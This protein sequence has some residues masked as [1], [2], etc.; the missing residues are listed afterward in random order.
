MR[1]LDTARRPMPWLRSRGL[2]SLLVVALPAILLWPYR[3][4]GLVS[5]DIFFVGLYA[6]GS[7]AS[8]ILGPWPHSMGATVAWRPLVL[9]S[10]VFSASWL[11]VANSAESHR[12]FN[13]LLHGLNAWAL[14]GLT[15]RLV[16]STAAGLLAACLFVVHPISHESVMWISG[17]TFPLVAFFGL[18]LLWWTTGHRHRQP[19]LQHSVGLIVFL[20][21]LAS[22]EFAVILPALV[23]LTA[24]V[25]TPSGHRSVR[26]TSAF[27]APYG[28]LLVL[29]LAFRWLWLSELDSD[30]VVV[31][32]ASE[33]AV[34]GRVWF[35][36]ARNSLFAAVRLC[37]WPWFPRGSEITMDVTGAL[38]T[39]VVVIAFVSVVSKAATRR[40][41]VY[42]SAFSVVWFLPVAAYIGFSDRLGYMSAAG[43]AALIAVF[44]TSRLLRGWPD[45]CG[46]LL[47]VSMGLAWTLAQ[48][49]HA[50]DWVR[51][52]A[53]AERIVA[54]AVAREPGPTTPTELHF[55]NVPQRERSALVFLTYFPQ[56]LWSRYDDGARRNVTIAMHWEAIDVVLGRLKSQAIVT[57]T[58]VYEWNRSRETFELQYD[59]LALPSRQN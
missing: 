9:A 12:L 16:G 15:T 57:P 34:A 40:I 27:I 35:R 46:W 6:P 42:W 43:V 39:A 14:C 19:W 50:S 30:V 10:Y 53:L 13:F 48:R 51:A 5:D 47:V 45:A 20:L 58:R 25:A 22:Y 11:P 36:I 1:V 55:V 18:L 59:A 8:V 4:A 41:G 52:G 7:W 17:R 31:A 23:G 3:Q 49:G 32:R 2:Y 29:Y 24:V 56:A 28:G 54:D 21:A 44:T 37:A 33:S 38:S 26:G